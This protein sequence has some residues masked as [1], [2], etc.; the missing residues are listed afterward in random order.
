MNN[1]NE[2]N[3]R[4]EDIEPIDLTEGNNVTTEVDNTNTTT[5]KN[6]N[7]FD[8]LTPEQKQEMDEMLD[9]AKQLGNSILG[10]FGLSTD[11]FKVNQDPA[12]GGYSIQFVP[13]PEEQD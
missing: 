3:D 12:S 11:N 8:E 6:K 9:Q 13:N 4:K 5:N 7:P 2:G 10:M 1:A